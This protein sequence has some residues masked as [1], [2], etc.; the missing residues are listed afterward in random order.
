[1]GQ[2]FKSVISGL[3]FLD[4]DEQP[5]MIP[6]IANS[7]SVHDNALKVWFCKKLS[8]IYYYKNKE[9]VSKNA[10][11]IWSADGLNQY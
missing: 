3:H 11:K 9:T 6:G 8:D 5:H 1:M 7:S 2:P 10:E 4:D